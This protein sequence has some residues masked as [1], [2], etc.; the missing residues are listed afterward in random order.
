MPD[1]G[2]ASASN[3]E[4]PEYAPRGWRRWSRALQNM[5]AIL[6]PSF[7]AA[8]IASGPFFALFDPLDLDEISPPYI[9]FSRLAGYTIGFFF[10]WFIGA[11][12]SAISVLLIRTSRRRDGSKR[13]G[14]N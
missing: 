5:V 14:H 3:A 9:G 12:A 10:F 6:W 2:F 11:I 13:G 8:C 1:K 4:L 7:L